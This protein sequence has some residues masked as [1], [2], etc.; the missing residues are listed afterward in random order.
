MTDKQIKQMVLIAF[1]V[2]LIALLGFTPVGLIP[3]GFINLTTLCIPVIVGTLLLG[4]KSGLILG[5]AFGTVSLISALQKVSGLVAPIMASSVLYV[6]ALCYIPRLLIPLAA[7]AVYNAMKKT[8]VG[9]GVAAAVG[10]LTNT[11]LYMGLMLLLYIILGIE[12]APVLAAITGTVALA[13]AG[14]AMVAVIITVPV[15][16]ALQKLKK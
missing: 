3:L 8:K 1:F 4:A 9:I 2:A 7:A 15:V 12:S 11:V 10:S 14:E 6:V 16:L 13:G 5:F